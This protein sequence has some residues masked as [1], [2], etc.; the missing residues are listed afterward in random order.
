[1]TSYAKRLTKVSPR[2]AVLGETFVF[3][4][5]CTTAQ[6]IDQ[7]KVSPRIADAM[8]LDGAFVQDLSCETLVCAISTVLSIVQEVS[9]R[10]AVGTR[11][12]SRDPV[13]AKAKV[14]VSMSSL[15]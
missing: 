4:K 9:P 8:Q 11:R 14:R 10:I 2:T 1:M 13:R 15:D 6:G 12:T 7:S 3:Q 5:L